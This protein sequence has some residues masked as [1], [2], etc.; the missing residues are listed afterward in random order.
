MDALER[1]EADSAHHGRREISRP[2]DTAP[3]VGSDSLAIVYILLSIAITFFAWLYFSL[4]K[5]VF[6]IATVLLVTTTMVFEIGTGEGQLFN[7]KNLLILALV[8]FFLISKSNA[9]SGHS[10]DAGRIAPVVSA[11]ILSIVMAPLDSWYQW[12]I[13]QIGLVLILVGLLLQD[14]NSQRLRR[15]AGVV[16]NISRAVKT[17]AH[18]K[19]SLPHGA[20]SVTAERTN[21][22]TEFFGVAGDTPN[23]STTQDERFLIL[24]PIFYPRIQQVLCKLHLYPQEPESSLGHIR[25][26]W[27]PVGQSRC[28][29]CGCKLISSQL[30]GVACFDDL[31]EVVPGAVRKLEA[32]LRKNDASG[33]RTYGQMTYAV[34]TTI[35]SF[36]SRSFQSN[37]LTG[38]S[39]SGSSGPVDA[40]DPA[41]SLEMEGEI[42]SITDGPYLLLCI[43]TG[44][45]RTQVHRL[46]QA[47]VHGISTWTDPLLFRQLRKEYYKHQQF[48]KPLIFRTVTRLSLVRV[49]HTKRDHRYSLLR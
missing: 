43:D 35:W 15:R 36:I 20:A 5:D 38:D 11:F 46:Y 26:R 47:Q 4:H 30:P 40:S 16:H 10:P 48:W 25:L 31:Y 41:V 29:Y 8:I 23:D 19:S 3:P 42:A 1:F 24:G 13:L 32:R 45:F 17:R 22:I 18:G 39:E 9:K 6:T 33:H 44:S 14:L 34:F 21:E 7:T 49:R 37:G 27:S 12:S 2:A 28:R